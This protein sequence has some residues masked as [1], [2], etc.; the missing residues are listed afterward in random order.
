MR[1]VTFGFVT[2]YMLMP[3]AFAIPTPVPTLKPITIRDVGR[4]EL[5]VHVKYPRFK[6]VTPHASPSPTS[7]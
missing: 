3:L 7:H 6:R 1:L 2:V 4:A 5:R